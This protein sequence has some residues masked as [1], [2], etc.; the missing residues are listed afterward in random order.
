MNFKPWIGERYEKRELFGLRILL[1]GESH[2]GEPGEENED[3]TI[4]V[5]RH[6]GQ[7]ARHSF[8]TITAKF[9]LRKGAGEWLSDDDRS[10]FWEKVA[11]YNYIQELVG[12]DS[13]IRPTSKMWQNARSS[14]LS[15]CDELKPELIVVLGKELCW[16]LREIP[17]EYP[18]CCVRH[19]SSGFSY[20]K[21]MPILLEAIAKAQKAFNNQIKPTPKSG[22]AY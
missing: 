16:N 9:L 17:G 7:Q 11:F 12:S 13:R 4:D 19:P 3:F 15:L 14:F 2:Y 8:F 21:E 10:D 6:W 20:E 22:A 5:V 18:Y 1:L